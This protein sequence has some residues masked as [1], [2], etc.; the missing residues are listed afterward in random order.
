MHVR[1]LSRMPST[2]VLPLVRILTCVHVLSRV[3]MHICA[4]ARART[5][6]CARE[7]AVLP[8]MRI[9]TSVHVLSRV[10]SMSVLLL[11][12]T[13]AHTTLTHADAGVSSCNP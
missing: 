2:S 13:G 1:V 9:L 8:L 4:S 3:R 5:V 12:G 10:S 11:V 7:R 6:L